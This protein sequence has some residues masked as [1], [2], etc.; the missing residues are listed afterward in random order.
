MHEAWAN[1]ENQDL[2]NTIF[3][4]YSSHWQIFVLTVTFDSSSLFIILIDIV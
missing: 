3:G 4:D 1:G 2:E